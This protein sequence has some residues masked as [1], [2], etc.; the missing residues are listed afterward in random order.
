[1]YQLQCTLLTAQY[2]CKNIDC[3]LLTYMNQYRHQLV[4]FQTAFGP[5][6]PSEQYNNTSPHYP[7]FIET[8]FVYTCT[9]AGS[10]YHKNSDSTLYKHCDNIIYTFIKS[11]DIIYT[12]YFIQPYD[13]FKCTTYNN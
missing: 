3:R 8:L 2:Y 1:M 9:A 5:A 12:V 6:L 7:T 13:Y 10:P 11:N 4:K